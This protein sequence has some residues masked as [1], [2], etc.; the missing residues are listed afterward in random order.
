MGIAADKIQAIFQPFNRGDAAITRHY[1]G[2]GLGLSIA[3]KLCNRMG[4]DITVQSVP[5]QGSTFTATISAGC[6]ASA[7][8]Y[9]PFPVMNLH[10][11]RA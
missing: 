9:A 11:V 1:G 2:T 10:P 7:A 5:G 6:K 4:G 8:S 3:K